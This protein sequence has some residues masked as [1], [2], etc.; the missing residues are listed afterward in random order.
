MSEAATLEHPG[1]AA[2]GKI[3][4]VIAKRPEKDDYVL[5]DATQDLCRY[6]DTLI[7]D[8]RRPRSGARERERLEHVN[9]VLTVVFG[10]HFTLGETPWDELSKARDWLAALLA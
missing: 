9:G 6:R 1:R 7:E 2:L 5:S 4:E 3:D 10:T 8:V